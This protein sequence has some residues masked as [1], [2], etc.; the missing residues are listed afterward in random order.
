MSDTATVTKSD[1]VHAAPSMT[2]DFSRVLSGEWAKLMSFRRL[3]LGIL[4]ALVGAVV[5][6]AAFAATVP[7]TRAVDA[8]ELTNLER[9][10]VS[11]LGADITNI[12][13]IIIAILFVSGERSSGMIQTSLSLSPRRVTYMLGKIFVLLVP[14]VVLSVIACW[15]AHLGGRV[16]FT[17]LGA[18]MDP[19]TDL[20]V[21][22]MIWG[23]V[24]MIPFY[25][26]F[27]AAL[28]FFFGSGLVSFLGVFLVMSLPTLS[29]VL[30]DAAERAVQWVLPAPGMHSLSG[31]AQPGD[32]EYTSPL[33]VLVL[34][35]W[36]VVALSLAAARFRRSDF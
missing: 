9:L 5:G 28:A 6:S 29:S 3:R 8:T 22:Q 30:P 34:V 31:A 19:I 25:A 33:G 17:M 11:M 21:Q 35:V 27:A 20:Q 14:A 10:Q 1:T 2:G 13:V 16:V 18:E 4:L 23:T 36:L 12:V 32:V 15:L 24:L 7:L 26:V